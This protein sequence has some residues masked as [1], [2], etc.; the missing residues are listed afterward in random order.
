MLP[1]MRQGMR[2][3]MRQEMGQEMSQEM[4][5]EMGQE[6]DQE[7]Q[8]GDRGRRCWLLCN[9]HMVIVVCRLRASHVASC[10]DNEPLL[11]RTMLLPLCI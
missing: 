8:Q 3:G 6:M 5:Q 11:A 9:S 10:F 1:A 4:S 2:Q 7:M